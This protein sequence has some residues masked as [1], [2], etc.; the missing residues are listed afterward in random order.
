MSI[1]FID[2][3]EFKALNDSLGHRVGNQALAAIAA[4][5]CAQIRAGD[6]LGRVGGDEFALLLPETGVADA[7]ALLE[8]I[9]AGVSVLAGSRG[10]PVS[11]SVGVASLG[12]EVDETCSGQDLLEF[13][14]ALL[15]RAKRE[16]KGSVV[17]DWFTPGESSGGLHVRDTV[18]LEEHAG[19]ADAF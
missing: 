17:S 15:F 12:D 11:I 6:V 2:V 16:T 14:D 19:P 8:R 7:R 5:I 3:D 10:W 13:A 4:S 1:A 18:A 9:A